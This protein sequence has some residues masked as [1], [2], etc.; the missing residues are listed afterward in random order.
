LFLYFGIRKDIQMHKIRSVFM[1][2]L[3]TIVDAIL[4]KDNEIL[5]VK[6]EY[7]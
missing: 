4:I 3:I 7:S 6:K 2:D 1:S 5:L